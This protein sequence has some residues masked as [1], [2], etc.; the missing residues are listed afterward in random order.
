MLFGAATGTCI[1]VQISCLVDWNS[2]LGASPT[3]GL[4]SFA[5]DAIHFHAVRF[6]VGMIIVA[7]L[8]TVCKKFYKNTFKRMY[9]DPKDENWVMTLVKFFN[10]LTISIAILFWIKLVFH[11]FGIPTEFDLQ[12]SNSYPTGFPK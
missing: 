9:P 10:Y 6:F 1:G 5:R 4:L 8:R 3:D 2:Y 7:I 11:K 12:P